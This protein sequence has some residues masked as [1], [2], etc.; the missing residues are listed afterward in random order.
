[1]FECP[2]GVVKAIYRVVVVTHHD[3]VGRMC[4]IAIPIWQGYANYY[5]GSNWQH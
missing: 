5:Y 2:F 1:M 4:I 3:L